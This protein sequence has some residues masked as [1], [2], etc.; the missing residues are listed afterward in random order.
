[1]WVV[2]VTSLH[3]VVSFATAPSGVER[4]HLLIILAVMRTATV[5]SWFVGMV[6]H[7]TGHVT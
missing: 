7:P 5:D 3:V 2:C 4:I 1:M 6:H